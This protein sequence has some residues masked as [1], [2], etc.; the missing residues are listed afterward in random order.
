MKLQIRLK[1]DKNIIHEVVSTFIFLTAVRNILYLDNNVQGNHCCIF[2][3]AP[4]TSIV[5][6]NDTQRTN[7]CVSMAIMVTRTR[8][9]G[10][11]YALPRA[12]FL[13]LWSADHK[14]SSGLPLR[15]S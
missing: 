10:T 11:L 15:S 2:M 6:G 3:A 5:N 9:N 7:V 8:H 14:W 13:K 12:A 1:S 4:S